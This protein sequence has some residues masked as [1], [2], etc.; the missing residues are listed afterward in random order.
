MSLLIKICGLSTAETLDAALDAGAD[1]VGL[2]FFARSPRNV[3]LEQAGELARRVEGRAKIVTLSVDPSDEELSAVIQ[4]VRPDFVQLHGKETPERVAKAKLM[5]GLPVIKAI[6]ISFAADLAKVSDFENVADWLLFDAKPPPGA[7]LPGGNGLSFDWNLL[8]P[9]PTPTK[10]ML[11][12]GLS[13]S[14]VA[15]AVTRVRPD[16]IDVSSGVESG[17]GRKDPD[18]IRQFIAEARAAA[19]VE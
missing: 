5:F 18:L 13:P 16:A 1:M 2:V 6:G 14:N 17:P 15:E 12:G 4:A 9:R 3:N 11:S 8:T 10:I 7:D 19:T